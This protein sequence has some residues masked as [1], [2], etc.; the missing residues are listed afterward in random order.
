VARFAHPLFGHAHDEACRCRSVDQPNH[1]NGTPRKCREEA[2]PIPLSIPRDWDRT[3]EP[4]SCPKIRRGPKFDQNVLPLYAPA[5]GFD[6][7]EYLR[8][9]YQVEAIRNLIGRVTDEIPVEVAAWR[10]GPLD[11]CSS[12]NAL[13]IGEE[14]TVKKAVFSALGITSCGMNDVLTL[15]RRNRIPSSAIA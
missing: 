8:Q 9:L 7:Y 10:A 2:R 4:V 15:D 13:T 14:R 5:D 6:F 1:R 3:F 11:R 12:P